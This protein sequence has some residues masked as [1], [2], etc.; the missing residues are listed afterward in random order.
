MSNILQAWLSQ[1]QGI[2]ALPTSPSEITIPAQHIAVPG[3]PA[4]ENAAAWQNAAPGL[5]QEDRPI[6]D[7]PYGNAIPGLLAG[8]AASLGKGLMGLMGKE[9]PAAAKAGE[10]D[11]VR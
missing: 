2:D 9:A 3:S 11:Q 10:F 6:Q 8:G 5:A 4:Q 1:I 7:D